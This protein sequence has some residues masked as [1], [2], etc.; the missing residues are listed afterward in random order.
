MQ[1]RNPAFKSKRSAQW[2]RERIDQLGKQE[3]QQLRTNAGTLG[4]TEIVALCDEALLTRPKGNGKKS[5][6]PAKGAKHLVSRG[7]AFEARG[8]H[9]EDARTSWGGVRKSDSTVVLSLWA[10]AIKLRDGQ[11]TYLLWAPNVNGSRPWSDTSAGKERRRHCELA[12]E[13]G[14]EGL[15]VYGE[16]LEGHIPEDKA[17]SVHGVDPE[18]VVRLEIEQH[19]EEFWATWGKKAV[20]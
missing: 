1:I 13:N 14:A 4:E 19:G 9:L 18:S 10:N 15:L 7:K 8:V 3:V 5:A 12:L 20:L 11:C 2:T 16:A 17:R 6:A